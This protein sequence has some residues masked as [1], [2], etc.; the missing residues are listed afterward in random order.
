MSSGS[1]WALFGTGSH[2]IRP[3]ICSPTHTFQFL[4]V[5][6]K[7][8][9][10]DLKRVS[11]WVIFDKICDFCAKT[12]VP[13]TASKKGAPPD[14]NTTLFTGREAPGE[15][16]SRAHCTDKKQLLEQQLK[17][18]SRCLKEKVDWAEN[19]CKK[20]TGLLNCSQT[21]NGLLTFEN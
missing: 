8:L 2:A 10:E 4:H 19:W 12:M 9:P 15:A 17:H 13:K 5:F 18:C 16:A 21:L 6:L 7:R 20:M 1:H 11:S 3:R 14:S